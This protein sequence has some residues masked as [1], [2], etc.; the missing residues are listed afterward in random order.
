VLNIDTSHFCI[1]VAC[2]GIAIKFFA[3][4]ELQNPHLKARLFILWIFKS[5]EHKSKAY[6]SNAKHSYCHALGCLCTT[7][8]LEPCASQ[9]S[10]GRASNPQE[11][12]SGPWWEVETP[13]LLCKPMLGQLGICFPRSIPGTH[14][15]CG[16]LGSFP[17]RH[18]TTMWPGPNLFSWVDLEQCE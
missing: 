1:L 10:W 8:T 11:D 2:C 4:F 12:C 13:T 15:C 5:F 3:G 6:G 14:W 18:Q 16:W 7:Q 17:S 9:S